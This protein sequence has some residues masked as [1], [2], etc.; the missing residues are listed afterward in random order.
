VE[1]ISKKTSGNIEQ[2]IW[3]VYLSISITRPGV[4]YLQSNNVPLIKPLM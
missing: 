1:H 2:S 4:V 3:I